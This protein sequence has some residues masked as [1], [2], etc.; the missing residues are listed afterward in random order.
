M[1]EL[2]PIDTEL[3]GYQLDELLWTNRLGALYKATELDSRRIVCVQT[4]SSKENPIHVEDLTSHVD[5]VA[6]LI[7]PNIV[8]THTLLMS[9]E[10]PALVQDFVA[11]SRLDHY[12]AEKGTL[13]WHFAIRI[14]RQLLS[15]LKYAHDS[16]FL[17]R[18][19]DPEHIIITRGNT[20]KVMHFG[21][22]H[23]V[24]GNSY[25]MPIRLV[26]GPDAVY[27]AP[28][29]YNEAEA[30][31]F[32]SDL[33]SL[34]LII[35]QILTGK[36]LLGDTNLSFEG[37]SPFIANRTR[38]LEEIHP[39]IPDQL[40]KAIETA[41][42]R[43]PTRRFQK[44]E[45]MIESLRDI[46]IQTTHPKV[47]Y[48]NANRFSF[49]SPRLMSKNVLITCGLFAV[50]ILVTALMVLPQKKNPFTAL[51]ING[52]E[53]QAQRPQRSL[54]QRAE[55]AVT[56]STAGQVVPVRVRAIDENNRS[57]R[58]EIYV[59]GKPIGAFTP[60]TLNLTE[61]PHMVAVQTQDPNSSMISQKVSVRQDRTTA[62][63][64]EVGR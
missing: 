18:R 3:N 9:S 17:H 27:S 13:H 19:L 7:H 48:L 61:G 53:Q 47:K 60:T 23:L 36:H 54:P 1:K 24:D 28:E 4:F 55:A 21:L 45:S 16:S 5:N 8:Q 57:I 31:D 35:H 12:L 64:I 14:M 46:E 63:T 38:F 52:T 59:D 58:A 15:A 51:D 37:Y 56:S 49:Q 26:S 40:F 42:E 33:Y 44:A 62:I 2:L 43:N 10:G 34:G 22:E 32:S 41:L 50:L 11:G 30:G 25:K 29:H 6:G 39:P 20:V